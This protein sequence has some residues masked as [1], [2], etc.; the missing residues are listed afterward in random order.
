MKYIKLSVIVACLTLYT[1]NDKASAPTTEV[2]PE[3]ISTAPSLEGTWELVGYYNYVDNK[4]SDSS[5]AS[6]DHRQIKMYTNSKMMWSKK[7]PA[8]STEWFAYGNY[9]LNGNTL[10]ERLEYGSKTMAPIMS[11]YGEFVYEIMLDGN[12]FSQIEIDEDGQK[13]YS[14]NYKRVE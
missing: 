14:E 2:E 11:T 9:K 3:L 13:I 1:C 7:R 5:R 12:N 10:I 4:I 6:I 8:D